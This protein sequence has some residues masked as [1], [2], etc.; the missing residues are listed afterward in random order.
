MQRGNSV[1][2]LLAALLVFPAGVGT[3]HGDV[4]ISE[5]L[6]SNE[7]GLRD[8]DGDFSDWIELCNAGLEP[9]EVT[10]WS[11]SDDVSEPRRWRLPEISLEPG[12]KVVIF[13]SGKDRSDPADE[14]HTSFRLDQDGEYLGLHRRDGSIVDAFL[15]TY[16]AQRP[17]MSYGRTDGEV[18]AP[19]RF[20]GSIRWLVPENGALGDSW[21]HRDFDDGGWNVG[22]ES[23]DPSG[24]PLG[25]FADEAAPAENP[26]ASIVVG[27]ASLRMYLRLGESEGALAHDELG[28]SSG[29]YEGAIAL[30]AP[31]AIAADVDTAADFSGGSIRVADA[32]GL[33][34]RASS[35]TIE[36]WI[37]PDVAKGFRWIAGKGESSS[38]ADYLLGI[39]S[40]GAV[41]FITQGLANVATSDALPFDGKRWFH[42]VG[43]QDLAAGR[44]SLY[45]DGE[46]AASVDLAER[47]VPGGT[48]LVIGDRP[49]GT[50]Q[51]FDGRIDEFAF[52]RR[53]LSHGE[54]RDHFQTARDGASLD[55]LISSNVE[56]AMRDRSASVFVRA[57]FVAE[58]P[59]ALTRLSL[60]VRFD[61]GFVA[62]I[63]GIEVARRNAPDDVT[64]ESAATTG[65]SL[66]ET[67]A[68]ETIDVSEHLDA[69]APGDVHVL[70]IQGLNDGAASPEF[71]FDA[72]VS[73]ARETT[74]AWFLTPT[75][76]A[77]N[78]DA[79]FGFVDPVEFSETRGFHDAPLDVELSTPTSNTVIR[80][81]LDASP[82]GEAS[83]TVYD[84]PI[85]VAG[86]TIVRAAAFREGFLASPVS[87]QTY[88]FTADILR[89]TGQG[90][91]ATW[92]SA[93]ADYA[94]DP[95]VVDD[96]RYRDSL[97]E[98]LRAIPSVSVSMEVDD[99]FGPQGI[100]S[101]PTLRGPA[102]ERA[103]SVEYFDP[104]SEN[105]FQI[106]AGIR[107]HGGSSRSPDITPQHSMRLHFP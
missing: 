51:P 21:T 37:Q 50:S 23:V 76:G 46:L 16:P 63:D 85:R 87:T 2:I 38:S 18:G 71:F 103:C 32:T 98:D 17:D 65:R 52:Y 107:M 39:T 22:D 57:Q 28:G 47:D 82:P 88:L 1:R 11:L 105:E 35:Y 86:T 41:R 62:W 56:A 25:Y 29:S 24:L 12:A 80:Y 53:A 90:F 42:V 69:L 60:S 26:Y 20:E 13:A 45:V 55:R 30:G 36:A 81:T 83:G 7:S 79:I 61:A 15:P 68:F 99:L 72:R 91:P 48:E 19:V 92:G 74:E 40:S 4:R 9:V 96:P 3:A 6:A 64:W 10:G 5:F 43:T 66:E 31:G 100:Y 33:D 44:V 95:T 27:E 67:L 77:A 14:L 84:G 58:D 78:R 8:A 70:A 73:G 93:R 54:I 97:P 101:N 102:W 89:Q 104:Q 34:G 94:M 106:D 75:P 59:A 49:F